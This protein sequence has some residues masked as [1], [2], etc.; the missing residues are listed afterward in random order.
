MYSTT[1]FS[2][3][4]RWAIVRLTFGLVQIF[5]AAF[6]VILLLSTGVTVWSLGTVV[7]T[8]LVTGTSLVLFRPHP[9]VSKAK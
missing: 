9:T 2:G 7:A 3:E 5:G 8:G 6:A 4:Q 1:H